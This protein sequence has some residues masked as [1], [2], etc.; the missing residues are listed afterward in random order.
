MATQHQNS[1]NEDSLCLSNT[2]A[3]QT[4]FFLTSAMFTADVETCLSCQLAAGVEEHE[5]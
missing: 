1:I 3:G 4:F 2:S 5:N